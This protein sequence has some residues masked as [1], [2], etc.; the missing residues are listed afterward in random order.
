MTYEAALRQLDDWVRMS[1][2]R[3]IA[4]PSGKT[5]AFRRAH[6]FDA[7][8][9]SQVEA[10]LGIRLPDAHRTLLTVVGVGEFFIDER[11]SALQVYDPAI[12]RETFASFMDD[13]GDLFRRFLPVAVDNVRQ[14][15]GVYLLERPQPDNFLVASH[16]YP[17]DD[18][19]LL[20]DEGYALSLER[21]I[22]E[23]VATEGDLPVH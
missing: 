10:E 23:A 18:W 3:S 21:W 1:D 5:K 4:M 19:P 6:L 7:N 16:E 12:V 15:I 20:A 22:Q 17:P 9:L 11:G 14:E 8:T 13:P 2:G